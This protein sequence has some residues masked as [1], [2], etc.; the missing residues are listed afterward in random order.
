MESKVE[1][2][3]L[4]VTSISAA[5]AAKCAATG[6]KCAAVIKPVLNKK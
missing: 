4:L 3:K 2:K 5:R 1:V 6:A